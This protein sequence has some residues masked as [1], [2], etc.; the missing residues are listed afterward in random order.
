[1]TE[2]PPFATGRDEQQCLMVDPGN[3]APPVPFQYEFFHLMG[4]ARSAHD[5]G[6]V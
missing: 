3:G 5:K 1:M 2:V 6:E 4:I